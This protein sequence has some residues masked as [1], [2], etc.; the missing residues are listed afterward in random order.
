[1]SSLQ[2]LLSGKVERDAHIYIG[3]LAVEANLVE[4]SHI[5]L[6]SVDTSDYRVLG[7]RPAEHFRE[8]VENVVSTA[9]AAGQ[10][11]RKHADDCEDREHR[12]AIFSKSIKWI[13]SHCLSSLATAGRHPCR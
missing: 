7:R 8:R 1:V 11:K 13:E 2:E 3:D 5:Q 6:L 12:L 4:R 9:E 10:H